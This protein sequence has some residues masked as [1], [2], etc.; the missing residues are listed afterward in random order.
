MRFMGP[1]SFTVYLSKEQKDMVPLEEVPLH[2]SR[3][4]CSCTYPDS[5]TSCLL[6]PYVAND[7]DVMLSDPLLNTKT[8]SGCFFSSCPLIGNIHCP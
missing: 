5:N 4:L 6:E 8:G 1:N 2:F 7:T 3:K